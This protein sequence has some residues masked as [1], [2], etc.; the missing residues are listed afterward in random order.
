VRRGERGV[1]TR[2]RRRTVGVST[3]G[4]PRLEA[5]VP[6]TINGIAAALQTTG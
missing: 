1:A 4:A 6:Q 2:V 3:A 5:L